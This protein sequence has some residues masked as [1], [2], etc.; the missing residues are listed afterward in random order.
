MYNAGSPLNQWNATPQIP[1][2]DLHVNTYK[3]MMN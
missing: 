2:G 3:T 1:T